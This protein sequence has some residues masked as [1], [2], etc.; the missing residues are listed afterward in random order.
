MRAV[1]VALA[2]A[3][4][5]AQPSEESCEDSTTWT[6]KGA[7]CAKYL[8]KKKGSK[9]KKNN[10]GDDGVTRVQDACPSLCEANGCPVVDCEDDPAWFWKK[11]NR[12]CAWLATRRNQCERVGN[13]GEAGIAACPTACRADACYDA[14]CVDSTTWYKK[15]ES[16]DCDW[17]AALTKNKKKKQCKKKG[18]GKHE[19][20]K[21]RGKAACPVACGECE[22][23]VTTTLPPAST[24]PTDQ[25][26]EANPTCGACCKYDCAEKTA[27]DGLDF[28]A[29]DECVCFTGDLADAAVKLTAL[30]DCA[31]VTGAYAQVDAGAGDD[32]V[33]LAGGTRG[34]VFGGDGDDVVRMFQSG[35]EIGGEP[36]RAEVHGG[37]GADVLDVRAEFVD[38]RGG[39]G[40][41]VI[42]VA[43]AAGAESTRGDVVFGG[44]GAGDAFALTALVDADVVTGSGDNV[45]EASGQVLRVKGGDGDD[46][47][48]IAGDDVYVEAMGG[49]DEVKVYGKYNVMDGGYGTG[50]LL[51]F[52]PGDYNEYWDFETVN[53]EGPPP[54]PRPTPNPTSPWKGL[55]PQAEKFKLACAG[56]GSGDEE[57]ELAFGRAYKGRKNLMRLDAKG[58]AGATVQHGDLWFDSA[59]PGGIRFSFR[60]EKAGNWILLRLFDDLVVSWNRNAETAQHRGEIHA[61]QW[62]ACPDY[63]QG[64][65]GQAG[66]DTLP[67]DATVVSAS[68]EASDFAYAADAWNSVEVTWDD[69]RVTVSLSDGSGGGDA[70]AIDQYAAFDGGALGVGVSRVDG[71][72]Y[73]GGFE[74]YGAVDKPDAPAAPDWQAA[75]LGA[76]H[77]AEA[78]D[79][80]GEASQSFKNHDGKAALMVADAEDARV[81]TVEYVDPPVWLDP[82]VPGGISFAVQ[83]TAD[84]DAILLGLFGGVVAAW[85]APGADWAS[86]GAARVLP[87]GALDLAAC[88]EGGG[89]WWAAPS[90]AEA[91]LP[92]ALDAWNAVEATWGDGELR[93]SFTA[94][95]RGKLRTATVAVPLDPAWA[96]APLTLGVSGGPPKPGVLARTY[97]ADVK[98]AGALEPPTPAP[99]RDPT[100]A[101][102]A[103]TPAPSTTTL[104]PQPTPKPTPAPSPAPRPTM[105][106]DKC[107][108][109]NPT[110]EDCCPNDCDVV[111][112]DDGFD[113]SG[114]ES[115]VCFFGDAEEASVTLTARADCAFVSGDYA[116]VD[117]GAGHDTI[118]LFDGKYG[119]AYGGDGRD[120]I[121][122]RQSGK[123]MPA[124]DDLFSLA[125]GGAGDDVIRVFADFARVR[126]GDGNDAIELRKAGGKVVSQGSQIWGG[127]GDDSVDAEDVKDTLVFGGGGSDDLV[128]VDAYR[129]QVDGGDGGD[130]ITLMT[131]SDS[132]VHAG[133]GN[134][135]IYVLGD[136][137][138]IDGGPGDGD[139]LTYDGAG[140]V[141]DYVESINEADPTA[142]PTPAPT[143]YE[144]PADDIDYYFGMAFLGYG[145]GHCFK[146]TVGENLDKQD[147]PF[148][149]ASG[150]GGGAYDGSGD[151]NAEED[152]YCVKASGGDQNGGVTKL[153]SGDHETEAEKRACMMLCAQTEGFTGCEVIWGQF[154]KGCYVHTQEVAKGNGVDKHKCWTKNA[155]AGSASELVTELA[156][157]SDSSS[158]SAWQ[159]WGCPLTFDKPL[160]S[161]KITL[162]WKDQGWGNKQG[163]VGLAQGGDDDRAASGLASHAWVTETIDLSVGQIPNDMQPLQPTYVVGGGGGHQLYVKDATLVVELDDDADVSG[164]LGAED[165]SFD[166]AC[167]DST[168][169]HKKKN[170]KQ[171]CAWVGKKAA[172]RCKDKIKSVDGETASD[173]CPVACGACDPDDPGAFASETALAEEG[174]DDPGSFWLAEQAGRCAGDDGA[175]ANA[176]RL[177][178]KPYDGS[179]TYAAECTELC[180]FRYPDAKGCEVVT[181]PAHLSG[182]YVHL[183]DIAGGC[184]LMGG[185]AGSATCWRPNPFHD[186]ARVGA[187]GGTAEI[188]QWSG[189]CPSDGSDPN[190]P[191]GQYKIG[192][193]EKSEWD[194]D[195]N[196]QHFTG[197]THCGSIGGPRTGQFY[198]VADLDTGAAVYLEPSEPSTCKYVMVLHTPPEGVPVPEP[199]PRPTPRPSFDPTTAPTPTPEPSL[200]PTRFTG[201][202]DVDA[203]SCADCCARN[204][205]DVSGAG[206]LDFSGAAGG[207][208][209]C[210]CFVGDASFKTVT[211]TPGDDC[212]FVAGDY[213][214]VDGGAGGDDIVLYGG[215]LSRAF[216]GAGADKIVVN[217]KGENVLQ[218][219]DQYVLV[220]GGAGDDAIEVLKS[221][222]HARGGDGDDDITVGSADGSQLKRVHAWGGDGDDVVTAGHVKASAFNGDK[223]K[224]TLVV[225]DAY[226]S[227]VRG[228]GGDDHLTFQDFHDGFVYAGSGND[229]VYAVGDHNVL[230]GGYGNFD[231]LYV[232]GEGNE[233]AYFEMGEN[234]DPIPTPMPT[235][236]P[237]PCPDLW[238]DA[239]VPPQRTLAVD[240]KAHQLVYPL[241]QTAGLVD[242]TKPGDEV[243]MELEATS[244]C[245]HSVAL[246][247]AAEGGGSFLDLVVPALAAGEIIRATGTVAAWSEKDADEDCL[248]EDCGGAGGG[249][250]ASAFGEE[251]A[252]YC[253]TSDGSDQNSGVVKLANWD[254]DTD[255]KKAECLLA[256]ADEPD[257]TGCE[258]IWGQSNAGCYVHTQ[259][260]AKGNGYAKHSCWLKEAGRRLADDWVVS[261]DGTATYAMPDISDSS[262]VSTWKAWGKSKTFPQKL[263]KAEITLTWKDQGWGNKKGRVG[264]WQGVTKA[265]SGKA[266]H[267]WVTET[268]DLD[269]EDLTNDGSAIQAKYVV[270]GGGGHQL[271]VKDATLVVTFEE[272]NPEPRYVVTGA[273]DGACELS[274]KHVRYYPAACAPPEAT[275]KPTPRPTAW[276]THAPTAPLGPVPAPTP[277][278]TTE[279]P[280]PAPV[281]STTTTRYV[282]GCNL[283]SPTCESC[284][285]LACDEVSAQDG[286]DFSTRDRCVCFSGDAYSSDRTPVTLTAFDDCAFVAG[287]YAVVDGGDGDDVI[288]LYGGSYGK[289]YGG[290]GDDAIWSRSG[291]A[292][293]PGAGYD[294]FGAIFGGAG[295][296]AIRAQGSYFQV[297]GGAGADVIV[298][299]KLPGAQT[300]STGNFVWGDKAGASSDADHI[301]LATVARSTVW[302]GDG[303]NVVDVSSG[304]DLDVHGGAGADVMHLVDLSDSEI[305]GGAG[306]DS[307]YHESGAYNAFHGGAG[308]GDALHL[309]SF[310]D[311]AYDGFE[312]TNAPD[313]TPGPTPAPSP[314]PVVAP[315]AQPNAAPTPRPTP[316]PTPR[317][318][319]AAPTRAPTT[320]APTAPPPVCD[321]YNP[322]CEAC[323]PQA[324]DAKSPADGYDFS[325]AAACV[326]F[327]GQLPN[328]DYGTLALSPHDD[329]AFVTGDYAG[330]DGGAGDDTIIL[331]GH[332]G[333]MYGRVDGGDGDDV[334]F[335]LQSGADL[336]ATR[337]PVALYGGAGDDAIYAVGEVVTILGGAGDDAIEL[338]PAPGATAFSEK[339]QVWGGLGA[340]SITAANVKHSQI[341]GG[342]KDA[343]DEADGPNSV[344]ITH[345]ASLTVWGGEDADS[346]VLDDVDE[347]YVFGGAGDDDVYLVGTY[348]VLY[349]GDGGSDILTTKDLEANYNSVPED[350]FE[351]F[352]EAKSSAA[353]D[354]GAFT[355]GDAFHSAPST[356][357]VDAPSEG[358]LVWEAHDFLDFHCESIGPGPDFEQD[359]AR[360]GTGDIEASVACPVSCGT[361]PAALCLD[362]DTFHV[363]KIS[364]NCAAVANQ[365]ECDDKA[366]CAWAPADDGCN[367]DI[368]LTC[369]SAGH[370]SN[371]RITCDMC[372]GHPKKD[373]KADG[374][375]S[376]A[377]GQCLPVEP[378][379]YCGVAAV[380]AF[381]PATCGGCSPP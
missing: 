94:P 243:T 349:G 305:Y 369:E 341:L 183:G 154:N 85:V 275:P 374:A 172:K 206:D 215:K 59:Q 152:G 262:S 83:P 10:V 12:N 268:I 5:R 21:A 240:G 14:P 202:C 235:G 363:D 335:G 237:T 333:G 260:V 371:L 145:A 119:R 356:E 84:D 42:S 296:D 323:C 174:F 293:V 309:A 265:H 355:E 169:W 250:S 175:P 112:P 79:T 364:T 92:W 204:C 329:C 121:T 372:A 133:A 366:D 205:A 74:Y 300:P 46:A 186:P 147:K 189:S 330:V 134:D 173:A 156:D 282:G 16:Q 274:L 290:A 362:D 225:D 87:A 122:L 279:P 53:G 326:C 308:G 95:L 238:S 242:W 216:G 88:A 318:T 115:C 256:C 284:C 66:C 324:C 336:G 193:Y 209:A 143:V 368:D 269:L 381:C 101:P 4:A 2:V 228:G 233:Y 162:T 295:D 272:P 167:A 65:D 231:T 106:T 164:A 337:V 195:V 50:D 332:D 114:R 91:W 62:D 25:C 52:N 220:E 54:T 200:R 251:Q 99:S 299:E 210:V 111:T 211:G 301:T 82:A 61:L 60:S 51:L 110:C 41:D 345:G 108:P 255:E 303:A 234:K 116:T 376:W 310:A 182:C 314:A 247:F 297:D 168:T 148:D 72:V 361:C 338:A 179:A 196:V 354:A 291:G 39:A 8:A 342:P 30:G 127:E 129:V 244:T 81:A 358:S 271:Y 258:V 360:V 22:A 70:F 11:A 194:G 302:S 367:P 31:F 49:S 13:T 28:S 27:A 224:D 248:T 34:K 312:S 123:Y 37:G 73:F 321:R 236:V 140:N 259:E 171:N 128:V 38:V 139:K 100:P 270:G 97:F 185:C 57:P 188:L 311:N 283:A 63:A 273:T 343:V 229:D 327:V 334:V 117:G 201:D 80:A 55:T 109:A 377:N 294:Q 230:D 40:A 276:P 198:I 347:T 149:E 190:P 163:R 378:K 142:Q 120:V 307:I 213:A 239:G 304:V 353:D 141:V 48:D 319:S 199:T 68:C 254:H 157:V 322:T 218:G 375:C 75:T 69:Q 153:A 1:L 287:D 155:C 180:A 222:V 315:T 357:C 226:G 350:D 43:P 340:D 150:G 6:R 257:F 32:T 365:G 104:P 146:A 158:T 93:V 161:A 373:C 266:P 221:F 227:T 26:D 223:G 316:A 346:I 281:T 264:L 252:G 105:E 20:K 18:K 298:V 165:G 246:G 137:N 184:E 71:P 212:L 132:H 263:A 136:D 214:T 19:G 289:V 191:G 241:A 331:G 7:T 29:S 107:D 380:A 17:L 166:S 306:D 33:F 351:V 359:C 219:D 44:D 280:T 232:A 144:A 249:D 77:W 160:K 288:Q 370:C 125:D 159:P 124:G 15:K 3:V 285:P 253:V 277:R 130:D 317:P 278:P 45:V 320:A 126:G 192:S 176:A 352:E 170:D 113:F 379:K 78:C 187:I 58:E 339:N 313:P 151:F 47:F 138:A 67:G 103:A 90:D 177:K 23:P 98:Y 207:G 24:L 286:F 64:V 135:A 208:D 328:R 56:D 197:G 89:D 76:G 203:P 102:T 267:S 217:Q 86:E 9:C 131:V 292:A 261:G 96:A 35:E 325:G 118:A 178:L 36:Y 181:A 245:A 344:K 348:N